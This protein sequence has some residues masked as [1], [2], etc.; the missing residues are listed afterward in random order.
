M[1]IVCDIWLVIVELDE[2]FL[3]QTPLRPICILDVRPADIARR[4]H[5]RLVAAPLNLL[6]VGHTLRPALNLILKHALLVE[7]VS[8]TR[9]LKRI[10]VLRIAVIVLIHNTVAIGT[11]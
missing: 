11:V 3:S 7:N 5:A 10:I 2:F 6:L 8:P 4:V 9:L 1:I